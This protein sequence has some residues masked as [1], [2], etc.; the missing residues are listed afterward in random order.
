MKLVDIEPIINKFK[1]YEC[2]TGHP[3]YDDGQEAGVLN[4]LIDLEN[5]PEIKIETKIHAYWIEKRDPDKRRYFEC[6]NCHSHENKHTAIKGK[7][8]WNCG[9]VMDRSINYI[10]EE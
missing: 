8:C 7:Y 10:I 1:N 4:V 3:E 6:S 5:A 9:A 2:F